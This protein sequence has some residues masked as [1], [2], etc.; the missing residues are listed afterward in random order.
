MIRLHDQLGRSVQLDSSAKRIVCLVPSITELLWS[1]DLQ[2][3][4]VGR[5][6]FCVLPKILK[7]SVPQVGGTKQVHLDKIKDLEPDFIICNK[8]ENTE[9]IVDSL[10]S[11]APIYVS[12]I[13]TI[14]SALEMISDIGR[15]TDRVPLAEQLI[16][17]IE[18]RRVAW[19]ATDKAARSCLYLIWKKPYMTIGVDT[20]I[21]QMLQEMNFSSALYDFRY[22]E[23]NIDQIRQLNPDYLLLSSEPFPF[24][25]KDIDELHQQLPNIP[26]ILVDGTYF[27]WYGNRILDAYDYFEQLEKIL[28]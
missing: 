13:Q 26:A 21:H 25:Q 8:E 4:L 15:L 18:E 6:K 10:A 16:N 9:E 2:Q 24:K 28:D 11:V 3:E 19:H 23:I 1:L 12:N 17:Q 14:H 22:P 5:T 7:T 27:S 20:F